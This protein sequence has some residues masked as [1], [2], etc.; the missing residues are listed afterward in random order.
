VHVPINITPTLPSSAITPRRPASSSIRRA[1]TLFIARRFHDPVVR[2][3]VTENRD[4]PI[5]QSRDTSKRQV[6]DERTPDL[7]TLLIDLERAANWFFRASA[8]AA[9]PSR[10]AAEL[11]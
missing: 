6:G 3:P 8:R 1:D 10:G 11:K 9:G 7:S 4:C 5:F 2:L